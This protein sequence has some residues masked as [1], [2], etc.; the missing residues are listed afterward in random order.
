MK[1]FRF[2]HDAYRDPKVQNMRPE[3]FKFWVNFLC[4]ASE[5]ED[6]G[7]IRSLDHL[8]RALGLSRRLT[9][10]YCGELEAMGLLHRGDS[11]ATTKL[12]S[13]NDFPLTPHNWSER[14]PEGDDAGL[15]KKRLR[16][17]TCVNKQDQMS[18]D[19]S[20]DTSRDKNGTLP[21]QDRDRDRNPPTPLRPDR[22][23]DPASLTVFDPP[24]ADPT[25]PE[26]DQ[27][28]EPFHSPPVVVNAGIPA[29]RSGQD[30]ADWSDALATLRRMGKTEVLA[31]D[32][33]MRAADRE[34]RDREAWR[35][36]Q[37]ARAVQRE[38]CPANWPYFLACARNATVEEF[39]AWNLKA[40]GGAKLR[41]APE[42]VRL[43]MAPANSPFWAISNKVNALMNG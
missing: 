41:A 33:E 10:R 27:D 11:E 21:V 13:S 40:N 24:S 7:T 37:A 5:S 4:V 30:L 36:L 1:W 23:P 22:P 14:Q 20:R 12:H 15:R 16:N 42:P 25:P 17:K 39:E 43:P 26:P 6:R 28:L 34:V 29:G 8:R 2:Y 9:E 32:L 19:T 18:R 38:S 35:F 31:D 3:L